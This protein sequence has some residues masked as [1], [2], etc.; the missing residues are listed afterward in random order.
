MTTRWWDPGVP[1]DLHTPGGDPALDAANALVALHRR[2]AATLLAA[3]ATPLCDAS[4]IAEALE[5]I[6][7]DQPVSKSEIDPTPAL[8]ADAERGVELVYSRAVAGGV[9]PPL[10]AVRAAKVYGVPPDHLGRYPS[11]A[12]DPRTPEPVLTDVADRALFGF[13]AEVTADLPR[14]VALAKAES[15]ETRRAAQRD[16]PRTAAG[17]YARRGGPRMMNGM[18]LQSWLDS[19]PA[20]VATPTQESPPLAPPTPPRE[21]RR[22]KQIR[23]IRR[24][25]PREAQHRE[26]QHREAVHREATHRSAKHREALHREAQRMLTQRAN[27]SR[28]RRDVPNPYET[29][30]GL[31][32]DPI[33]LGDDLRMHLP[34]EEWMEFETATGVDN[35]GARVFRLGALTEYATGSP[36]APLPVAH[37]PGATQDAVATIDA[38]KDSD[39][40]YATAAEPFYLDFDADEAQGYTD[41]DSVEAEERELTR[42]KRKLLELY[43]HAHQ[44]TEAEIPDARELGWVQMIEAPPKAVDDGVQLR[45]LYYP[46]PSGGQTT[47]RPMPV[48]TQFTLKGM[49]GGTIPVGGYAEEYELDPNQV[50]RVTNSFEEYYDEDLG[51]VVR[52]VELEPA[53]DVNLEAARMRAK[54]HRGHRPWD[55]GKAETPEVRR[56]AQADQPRTVAG[57]YARRGIPG[58][59]SLQEWLDSAPA[60]E[61]T[62]TQK[63]V[64]EP[65]QPREIR[66]VRQI[67]RIRRLEP[68]EVRPLEHR[69]A[70]HREAVHREAEHRVAEVREAAHRA[71]V[72]RANPSG[73]IDFDDDVLPYNPGAS[74]AY[75]DAGRASKLGLRPDLYDRGERLELTMGQTAEIVGGSPHV[76]DDQKLTNLIYQRTWGEYVDNEWASRGET[77]FHL[78]MALA[79]DT[80]SGQPVLWTD[81]ADKI[82]DELAD[83][84]LSHPDA[85][86]IQILIARHFDD[87]TMWVSARANAN[88]HPLSVRTVV[89]KGDIDPDHPVALTYLGKRRVLSRA[90]M[91]DQVLQALAAINPVELN[92]PHV[93]EHV[94]NPWVHVYTASNQDG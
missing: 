1:V 81:I 51:A 75:F 27:L 15:D 57:L 78:K 92:H 85:A 48:I 93:T 31:G 65:Q 63:P 4:T 43:R 9:I 6:A 35:S 8:L 77:S 24:L 32:Y 39:A 14:H 26:A 21:I 23:R 60:E 67:R 79:D 91:R 73:P 72:A 45:L 64:E 80:A 49:Q 61:A 20:E 25:A 68:R 44:L 42:L 41:S 94:V 28:V 62:G 52:E 54:A 71:A 89:V 7:A 40:R 86:T 3:A 66:R 34:L 38:I 53:P 84:Y 30:P 16:Q 69:E 76:D 10:A 11:L 17:L 55:G 88:Q 74:Y 5:V 19:A 46:P 82:A 22:V 33:E 70:Q 13:I 87:N 59:P 12:A 36:T 47:S 2:G 58:L 83:Y 56:A 37:S 90:N 18:D 50:V 29:R